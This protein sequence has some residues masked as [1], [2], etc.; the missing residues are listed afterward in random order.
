MAFKAEDRQ[1]LEQ[2]GVWKQCWRRKEEL[3]AAGYRPADAQR[4]ALSEFY[5]PDDAV[6]P[7]QAGTVV[8]N[9]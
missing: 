1:W 2:H 7:A 8:V 6:A 3:K 5:H 4:I 9:P